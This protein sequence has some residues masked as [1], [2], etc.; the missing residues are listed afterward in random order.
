MNNVN[1]LILA[2]QTL[3]AEDAFRARL[4]PAQWA[5]FEPYLARH[6]L[7]AGDL[8][9]KQGDHDHTMY[10]L[11]RGSLQV[12]VTRTPPTSHRVAILR[13]GSVVGE[14]GLFGDTARM[15]NVEAM[16]PCVVWALRGPRF[17]EMA[18][19]LPTL[20]LEVVR[21]AAAVLAVRLRA[22]MANST[23]VS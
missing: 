19:R 2:V 11:E 22:N 23:P 5:A 15:A 12:F 9:I 13:A 20:A 7:R 10:L 3:N 4:S 18:A 6:E 16:T 14:A 17:E 8:L 1:E 21:G